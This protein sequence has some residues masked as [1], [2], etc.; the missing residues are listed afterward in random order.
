M[1]IDLQF[2]NVHSIETQKT[3]RADSA[4]ADRSV[5]RERQ[6]EASLSSATSNISVLAARAMSEPDVRTVRVNAL[7][8]SIADGSYAVQPQAI[9]DAMLKDIF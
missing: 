2:G 6:D 1:R 3:N 5:R 9:A 8:A 7:R 4:P